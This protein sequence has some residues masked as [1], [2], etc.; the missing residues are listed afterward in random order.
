M[1]RPLAECV[2]AQGPH[3]VI[4]AFRGEGLIGALFSS[5]LAT[6][7]SLGRVT[8]VLFGTKGALEKRG[9][10]SSRLSSTPNA[11]E[12]ISKG[13]SCISHGCSV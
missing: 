5:G 10:L 9:G 1:G 2:H 11:G 13:G 6:S 3:G 7:C 12:A 4:D 8:G